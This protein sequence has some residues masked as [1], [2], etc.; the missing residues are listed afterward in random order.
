MA[1][2][3]PQLSLLSSAGDLALECGQAYRSILVPSSYCDVLP[4][5]LP[6]VAPVWKVDLRVFS[7]SSHRQP[8]LGLSAAWAALHCVPP[9]LLLGYAFGGRGAALRWG[10]RAGAAAMAAALVAALLLT[11]LLLP[12][13]YDYGQARRPAQAWG[14]AGWGE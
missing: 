14:S 13:R 7:V 6:G 9:A 4:T 10:A 1:Y 12:P 8:A 3:M 2:C 5:G 11:G